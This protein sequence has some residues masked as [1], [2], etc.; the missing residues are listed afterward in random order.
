MS[1]YSN[2]EPSPVNATFT[3]TTASTSNA[4][5][6]RRE[7]ISTLSSG[8]ASQDPPGQQTEEQAGFRREGKVGQ[9]A[10]DDSYDEAG[11]STDR[12]SA[13]HSDEYG[14]RSK[15]PWGAIEPQRSTI[16]AL[17]HTSVPPLPR[18]PVTTA[19]PRAGR[20][21]GDATA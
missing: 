11:G 14:A 15:R 10:D 8:F 19:L 12:E 7:V 20:R 4:T 13:S 5:T 2:T 9:D 1:G 17:S 3:R 18:C 21:V 6:R 16:A